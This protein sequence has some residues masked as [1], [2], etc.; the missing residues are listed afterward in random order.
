MAERHEHRLERDKDGGWWQ[1]QL[2][3][4]LLAFF[5]GVFSCFW[6]AEATYMYGL[7]DK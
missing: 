5:I 1:C 6:I 7:S 4:E 2:H 3:M